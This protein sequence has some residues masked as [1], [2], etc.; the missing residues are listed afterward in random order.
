M[1]ILIGKC[2]GQHAE[3]QHLGHGEHGRV[4]EDGV[5]GKKVLEDDC[6]VLL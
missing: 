1:G 5:V 6:L 4:V 3:H 2:R